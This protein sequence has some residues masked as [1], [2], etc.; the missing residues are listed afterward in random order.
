MA[1]VLANPSIM[2]QASSPDLN[3]LTYYNNRSY[4]GISQDEVD[5]SR[6]QAL[7]NSLHQYDPNAQF[8]PT[9]TNDGSLLGY[10]LQYD[11]SK[12]PGVGNSG[13]LGGSN[14]SNAGG[15]SYASGS[16]FMPNFSTVQPHMNLLN[17][18]AVGNSPHYGKVTSNENIY[19]KFDPMSVIGPLLVGGFGA[20][21]GGGGVLA[22]LLQKAPQALSGMSNGGGFNPYQIAGMAL[23]FVPGVNPMMAF[24][25]RMGLNAVG[26]QQGKG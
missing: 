24:L 26:S 22:S 19:D 13:Q 12:L 11:P 7:L 18:N 9:Y 1:Q 14:P 6:G 16:G 25:G 2:Q 8:A 15:N 4:G 23:P 10:Q 3:D 20:L 17:P 5:S 21:A